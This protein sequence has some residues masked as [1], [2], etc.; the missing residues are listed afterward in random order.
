MR[1][2]LGLDAGNTVIK[3]VLFDLDGNQIAMHALDGQTSVPQPGYVERDLNGRLFA[4]HFHA[5]ADAQC[6]AEAWSAMEAA[7]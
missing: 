3:A 2:L 5:S 7:S 4:G 1:Y 6:V